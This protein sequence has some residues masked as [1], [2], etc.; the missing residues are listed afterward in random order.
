MRG[1]QGGTSKLWVMFELDAFHGGGLGFASWEEAAFN[2]A[3]P[4]ALRRCGMGDRGTVRTLFPALPLRC[5]LCRQTA[6]G[7][8]IDERPC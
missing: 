8:T 6:S 5:L 1:V 2:G 7:N 4:N 3:N